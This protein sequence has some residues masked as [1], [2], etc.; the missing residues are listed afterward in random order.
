VAFPNPSLDGRFEDLG[1]DELE[2]TL[3][4]TFELG[5]KRRARTDAARSAARSAGFAHGEARLELEAETMRRFAAAIAGER[6]L[7]LI[8]ASIG[9]ASKDLDQIEARVR[10]GATRESDLMQAEIAVEELRAERALLARDRDKALLAL[11]ALWGETAPEP[12]TP[13]ETFSESVPTPAIDTLRRVA[14][15]HP[16]ALRLREGTALAAAEL[17]G[18]RAARIPDLEFGAG[19]VRYG[20]PAGENLVLTASLPLP[21]FDRN[22]A[23]IRERERLAEAARS[24]MREAL[25]RREA[26]LRM[27][28]SDLAAASD[29]LVSLD[30]EII[31]RARAAFERIRSYYGN[32]AASFFE[33]NGARRDLVRL[34]LR[35]IETLHERSLAAADL[36]ETTGYRVPVF[37][38]R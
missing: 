33:M 2:L 23:A 13:A 12:L 19:V 24:D 26:D 34:Q 35:R 21:V 30:A 15:G 9:L 32:G 20:E 4:Q 17:A 3:S 18:A 22:R 10:A 5:G 8:D 37:S 11:A 27:I 31:P 6:R 25:T 14:D 36:L 29:A 28:A 7:V 1:R 16:A 38:A